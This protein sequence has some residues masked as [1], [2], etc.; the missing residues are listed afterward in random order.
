MLVVVVEE[1]KKSQRLGAGA[2]AEVEAEVEVEVE[3]TREKTDRCSGRKIESKMNPSQLQHLFQSPFPQGNSPCFT[4]TQRFFFSLH[5]VY[6][7]QALR[8]RNAS[9]ES[10]K[11]GAGDDVGCLVLSLSRFHKELCAKKRFLTV[12]S[13]TFSQNEDLLC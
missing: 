11:S 9:F 10:H 12:L 13:H 8:S 1:R 6:Q 5:Q 3:V 2:I 4:L 7:Q